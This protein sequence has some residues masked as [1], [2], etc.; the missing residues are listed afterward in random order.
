V[1]RAPPEAVPGG[2]QPVRSDGRHLRGQWKNLVPAPAT[3]AHT[4]GGVGPGHA[5][6]ERLP[7]PARATPAA[8]DGV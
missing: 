8:A 4:R 1:R 5:R 3:S 2:N 7:H 6:P